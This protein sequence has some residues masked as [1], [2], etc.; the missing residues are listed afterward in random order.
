MFS[1]VFISV[2]QFDR[3]VAFYS[4][5]MAALGLEQRFCQP[6]TPWAGWHSPGGQRPLLLI[7]HPYNGQPHHPGNGQ[8]VAL[9][10]SSR[11]QVD[12]ATSWRWRTA[13]SATARQA[14][15]RITMPTITGRI[16]GIRMAT[17]CAWCAMRHPRRWRAKP[18]PAYHCSRLN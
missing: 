3:A 16:F 4:P 14:C 13:A 17:S 5:V 11:A 6:D 12:A 9:S 15:A 8:M 2:S 7:G 10:A 1:H 18:A